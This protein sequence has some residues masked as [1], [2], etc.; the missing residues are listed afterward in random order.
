VKGVQM[1]VKRDDTEEARRYWKALEENSKIVATWPEWKL[2]A[3]GIRLYADDR[4]DECR[5]VVAYL[6]EKGVSFSTIPTSGTVPRLYI[7]NTPYEGF[8]EIK[9]F[10][11]GMMRKES[12]K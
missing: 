1:K 9:I 12:K 5:E 6:L 10:V 2:G 7:G 3:N 4:T 8:E 11:E